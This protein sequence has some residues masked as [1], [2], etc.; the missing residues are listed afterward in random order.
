M[1]VLSIVLSIF[2]F[3][4]LDSLVDIVV[5]CEWILM[6][7]FMSLMF[8]NGDIVVIVKCGLVEVK[9]YMNKNM[10]K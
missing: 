2:E 3:L 10:F 9:F 7:F 8:C 5:V 6:V 1:K 4:K